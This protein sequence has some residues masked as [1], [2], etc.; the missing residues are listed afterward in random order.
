MQLFGWLIKRADEPDNNRLQP[1]TAPIEDDGA[2]LVQSGGNFGTYV[3][4]EG[5]AKTEAELV[6]KYR[7]MAGH[8]EVDAAI[9]DIVNEAIVVEKTVKT[10][11]IN[12]DE[13]PELPDRIKDL[14]TDEFEEILTLLEFNEKGYDIFRRWYVDGRMYYQII[15]D[16]KEPELGI[17]ELRYLD[18][19]KLRKVRE[20]KTVKQTIPGGA[21]QAPQILERQETVAEFFIFNERGFSQKTSQVASNPSAAITGIRIAKDSILHITSGVVDSGSTIVLSHLHKAIKPLNQ[22]R[23]IEDAAVIYRLSRAPERRVFNIDVGNLPKM[24]AEQY[25]R[26]VMTKYKNK[27][28]YDANTGEIRDDRKFMT[29]LEDFWLPKRDGKGTTIDVLP[30]GQHLGEMGDIEYFLKK[31]YKALNVPESRLEQESIF[32]LGNASE[33]NRDEVKFSKFID[34]MR[35]RFNHIFLDSLRAQLILKGVM[36]SVEW[37]EIK[38]KIKFDYARDN[39]YSE[40][41]DTQIMA[42]R[43]QTA[44]LLDP[45]VG[46]YFSREWVN[47][48]V[49]RMSDAQIAHEKAQI[50]LEMDDPLYQGMMGVTPIGPDGMAQQPM[51]APPGGMGG[52]Q[53]QP[54]GQDPRVTPGNQPPSQGPNPNGPQSAA[55]KPQGKQ[56][57]K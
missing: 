34:R 5:S 47:K 19:R 14:I 36:A 15:I 42:T 4:L 52:M 8:P 44:Q 56:A 55:K 11:E 40:L 26:D 10:I 18:P 50:M 23:A 6:L 25:M 2:L 43:A 22:L 9:D 12:M 49:W 21:G 27:I 38:Q 53:Q 46:A 48:N 24:K 51:G 3:D 37:E 28:V 32:Q 45:Y 17:Q 16:T 33:V 13:L 39:F 7:E 31:L 1:I 57:A 41:K 54:Q 20:T 29:M 35:T 30:A